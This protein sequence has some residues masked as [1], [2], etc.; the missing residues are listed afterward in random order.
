MLINNHNPKKNTRPFHVLPISN[1]KCI[2]TGIKNSNNGN[3]ARYELVVDYR[4]I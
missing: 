2:F 3:F 1:Q 4:E